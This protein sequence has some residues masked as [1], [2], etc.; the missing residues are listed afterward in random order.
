MV[1]TSTRSSNISLY[2]TMFQKIIFRAQLQYPHRH[3][4]QST[5]LTSFTSNEPFLFR[6][7]CGRASPACWRISATWAFW[8]KFWRSAMT[9][10][11]F[12]STQ[13]E[14]TSLL[15]SCLSQQTRFVNHF[16]FIFITHW[17]GYKEN[18][19][20]LDRVPMSTEG[21]VSR[22]QRSWCWH[23]RHGHCTRYGAHVRNLDFCLF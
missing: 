3:H 17:L 16:Y 13:G 11:N 2:L 22:I 4:P 9:T 15:E 6:P 18:R 19:I 8:T 20:V 23:L 21:K 7:C 10:T 5:Y 1:S 14:T 12:S